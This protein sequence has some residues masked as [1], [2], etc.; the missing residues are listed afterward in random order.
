MGGGEE[1]GFDILL[2]TDKNT[3]YQQNL[4][5]Q[6][7]AIVLGQQAMAETCTPHS[8]CHRSRQCGQT[9]R[10]RRSGHRS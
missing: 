9:Q 3:C 5:G 7:I 10:L 1:A 8:A 6:K 4:A 2:T